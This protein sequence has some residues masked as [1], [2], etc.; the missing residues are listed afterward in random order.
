MSPWVNTVRTRVEVMV[1][2][3][4]TLRGD[5]HLS[6]FAQNHSGPE[7]V[8]DL[9]NRPEQFF[10]M[11]LDG[12]QPIMVAKEQ[13]LVFRLPPHAPITD[14]AR[15]SAARKIELSVE[16]DD[17]SAFEGAVLIELPPDRL[18]LLDFLN[19][20]PTFFALSSPDAVRVINRKHVRC[21]SPLA[22]VSRG[23]T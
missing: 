18:R 22:Q 14:P 2:G 13:V 17:G 16:L 10:A 6:P 21:V 12:E 9:L 19:F 3:R 11:T 8:I 7:S 4:R 23:P 20:T 1:T 15:E 5:V